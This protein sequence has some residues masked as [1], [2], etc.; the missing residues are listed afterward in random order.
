MTIKDVLDTFSSAGPLVI[1][2]S[3][4]G[5]IT[6][7]L[8]DGR[9][10]LQVTC[11]RLVVSYRKAAVDSGL[12]SDDCYRIMLWADTGRWPSTIHEGTYSINDFS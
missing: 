12:S 7:R 6:L 4:N 2:L 1:R 9:C 11:H 5:E 10:P 8:H 3:D